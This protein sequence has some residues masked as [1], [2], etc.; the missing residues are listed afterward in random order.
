MSGPGEKMY[1]LPPAGGAALG[2]A[3]AITGADG[4]GTVFGV[5]VAALSVFVGLMLMHRER[6]RRRYISD[7]YAA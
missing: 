6:R 5:T 7:Q 2:T 3:L 4:T 1:V